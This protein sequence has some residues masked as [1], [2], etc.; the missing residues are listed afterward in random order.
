MSEREIRGLLD[1]VRAGRLSRRE[2]VQIMVAFGLTVPLAG[3]LLAG[4]GFARTSPRPASAPTKRGGGGALRALSWDAPSLLNPILALGLKDWN[5]CALFYEPLVYFDPAGN[6][7]P[8]LAQ[9]VPSL[10][11]GGV[12]R[13]GTSVTWKLKHGVSW[14]DG[15]PFT[16][17]DVVFT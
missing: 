7:V 14:H 6:L 12:A 11:N 1:D 2:F 17:Q 16:A 4:A 8:V 3:Q 9:D 5:A 10:Q 15:K 13:D